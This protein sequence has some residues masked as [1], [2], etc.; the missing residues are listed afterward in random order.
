ML[1]ERASRARRERAGAELD[2]QARWYWSDE[3]RHAAG[4]LDARDGAPHIVRATLAA[5]GIRDDALAE[6]AAERY[7]AVRDAELVWMDGAPAA[8]AA[9]RAAF[10][11]LALVTNGAADAQRAKLERFALAA[12]FDHVQI[13]GAEGFGKPARRARSIARSRRSARPPSARS[14]SATTSPS[15]CSAR[16]A[17]GSRRSGSTST[18]WAR[19]PP[20]AARLR[21]AALDRARAGAPRAPPHPL[22]EEDPV[23]DFTDRVAVVTGAAS[24]IGRALSL[25]LARRGAHVALVDVNETG[26]AG[27]ASEVEA[28]GRKASRHVADVADR[29]RMAALP[30][31]VLRAH[32]RVSLLV[33]NAGVSV[34]AKLRGP[35]AR[36]LRLDRRHQLLGRRP[37]LQF[38][39]PHLR[40]E[41][42]AHIVNLSSMF[43]LVGVPGQISYCATKFAVRG[44]SESLWTELAR[45]PDRRHLRAPGRHQDE[46]RAHRARH[47]RR[48]AHRTVELFDRMAMAPERAAEQILRAVERNRMRAMICREAKISDWLKRLAPTATQRLV[49]RAIRRVGPLA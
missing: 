44:F 9:L 27:T 10:P 21:R 26:L 34:G 25:A 18:A 11:R 8:L 43:G 22:V 30:D 36:G 17:P 15:T 5:L 2:R 46:H 14:W 20:R 4:R 40:R 23:R 16:S 31:E 45:Y 3:A 12:S 38:F 19:R 13:E 33:N 1:G 28:L 29:E 7:L 42:E 41:P 39:L 6:A 47:D 49:Y 35:L 32:G 37:R 24:G 48:R